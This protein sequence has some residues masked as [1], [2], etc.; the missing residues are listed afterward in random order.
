M[1][2]MAPT[3][4]A[5]GFAVGQLNYQGKGMCEGQVRAEAWADGSDGMVVQAASLTPAGQTQKVVAWV[6]HVFP[7]WF[8]ENW[9]ATLDANDAICFLSSCYSA[10]DTPSFLSSVGGRVRFGWSGITSSGPSEDDMQLLMCRANCT[11]SPASGD[12]AGAY[13]I[14]SY[15]S[16]F[17]MY[18]SS[19]PST[20]L[21]PRPLHMHSH[22][23]A[24]GENPV[25]I[26]WAMNVHVTL[27]GSC[28]RF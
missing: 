8:S 15:N 13:L 12:L 25:E 3:M 17:E 21:C 27:T 5:V 6:V 9:A 2:L 1:V 28:Q 18:P 10:D 7:S 22:V 26:Q 4:V 20:A 14:G 19:P 16:N 11:V 24:V 23:F